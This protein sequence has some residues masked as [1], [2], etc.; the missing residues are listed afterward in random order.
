MVDKITHCPTISKSSERLKINKRR[1]IKTK[2]KHDILLTNWN[3]GMCPKFAL[4]RE[5]CPPMDW[6]V[7]HVEVDPGKEQPIKNLCHDRTTQL[8]PDMVGTS[9]IILS[10][11]F[12][13]RLDPP[14]IANQLHISTRY[15]YK[16]IEKSKKI[17]YQNLKKTVQLR[18]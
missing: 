13:E 5:L 8:W 6:I 1:K 15:V 2:E 9:E 4:C 14:E 12:F 11:F 3:C 18:S 7:R 16:Q 17:L 10:L